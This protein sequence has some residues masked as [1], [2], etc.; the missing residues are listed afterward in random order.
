VTEQSPENDRPRRVRKYN[1]PPVTPGNATVY[2]EPPSCEDWP[3]CAAEN[4]RCA[5][6]AASLRGGECPHFPPEQPCQAK[7]FSGE[8][9]CQRKV[10]A[11]RDYC[12]S[13]LPFS[14]GSGAG[15]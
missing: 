4:D 11:G 12:W 2:F 5:A 3:E 15:T 14:P 9:W 1:L 10:V 7:D 13:H 8:T 6:L